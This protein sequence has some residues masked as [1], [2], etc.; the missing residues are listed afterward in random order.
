MSDPRAL[1]GHV[2]TPLLTRITAESLD[3]DYRL[4]A[5]RRATRPSTPAPRGSPV[6]SAVVTAVVIAVFGVLVATAAVQTSQDAASASVGRDALIGRVQD[7][8]AGL[9]ALQQD[10][11]DLQDGNIELEDDVTRVALEGQEQATRLLR[12]QEA[13]GFV[14]VTGPGVEV[15]VNDAPG[16]DLSQLV[17]DEDLAMLVDGLWRAGAEAIAINNQRITVLTAIRNV[18]PA[19]RVNSR[20]VNP[21]YVVSA[22]GDV[23][24]LQANLLD[25][26]HG[27]R[28]FD[29]AENIGF[30]YSMQNEEALSLPAARPPT[31][32]HVKAGTA[33]ENPGVEEDEE[34]N[35]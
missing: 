19:I 17:R 2:T 23:D 26:T 18:G 29:L 3:E 14:A 6:S 24:T 7:E 8:R 4:V 22:I 9:A 32:T 33:G 16:G 21:P 20:P 28:F 12:L 31:L 13:T 11:A 27:Q 1:P 34:V 15:V 10:I 35:P 30:A 5:L 25:T